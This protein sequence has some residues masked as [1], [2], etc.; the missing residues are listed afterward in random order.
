MATQPYLDIHIYIY[1][2][3]R[4]D[5][6]VCMDFLYGKHPKKGSW[7]HTCKHTK[8]QRTHGEAAESAAF[9]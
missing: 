6:W 7:K 8:L 5:L 4:V 2:H 3:N 9:F 1:A